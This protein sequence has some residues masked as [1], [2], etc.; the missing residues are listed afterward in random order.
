MTEGTAGTDPATV[1]GFL[2]PV[3]DVTLLYLPL[4]GAVA[5]LEGR[6]DSTTTW[7]AAELGEAAAQ[8]AAPPW[9]NPPPVHGGDLSPPFLGIIPSRACHL[10]CRYCDFAGGRAGESRLDRP[11]AL[12]AVD[13]FADLCA[14]EERSSVEVEF[15][16]GEPL[17]EYGTVEAI[18]LRTWAAA[19]EQGIQPVLRALTSG[20]VGEPAR[21]LLADLFHTVTV[22]LDG[23][24]E[25][26]DRLRP[27]A[28][29][30]GTFEAAAL[31]C[32]EVGKG[33]ARLAIRV[34][35]TADTVESMED[36]ADFVVRRFQP[37]EV[38]FE[39]LQPGEES[40]AAG[41][42]PP[43][44]GAFA[45]G[46]LRASRRLEDRGVRP[47]HAT[48]MLERRASSFCPV[49]DDGLILG[50]GGEMTACYLSPR[51]WRA[52][53]LDLSFGRFRD[54]GP[55]IDPARLE[56]IRGL[57]V[58]YKPRCLDCFARWHCGGGCHVHHTWPG[59]SDRRDDLCLVTRVL[60]RDKL[61]AAV[62]LD[63][64]RE[65]CAARPSDPEGWAVELEAPG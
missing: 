45:A 8:V 10:R 38:S 61:L 33:G 20:V 22:S 9:A 41:L 65:R 19:R 32:E 49:A 25:V 36:V 57:D 28:G 58:R 29:G 44:G 62:G 50:P 59:C 27:S 31:T 4:D 43:A 14:A 40:R 6:P 46:F 34:C 5:V 13:W 64:H 1:K 2:L 3:A 16:G 35:V 51:L 47:V 11:L 63:E 37:D 23:P 17:L 15:F 12:A 24:P 48:S 26:H 30:G 7:G 39:P 21:H 54:D 53:G 52:R 42:V 18:A 55:G 60:V 56:K